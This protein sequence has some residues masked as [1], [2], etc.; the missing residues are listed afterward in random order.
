M[1]TSYYGL[2]STTIDFGNADDLTLTGGGSSSAYNAGSQ[3]FNF[4]GF[5]MRIIPHGGATSALGALAAGNG[6]GWLLDNTSLVGASIP[7]GVWTAILNLKSSDSSATGDLYVRFSYVDVSGPTFTT[8]GDAVLTAQTITTAGAQYTLTSGSITGFTFPAGTKLYMEIWFNQQSGGSATNLIS[9]KQATTSS[10][11]PGA[12][13]GFEITLPAAGPTNLNLAATGAIVFGGSASLGVNLAATGALVLGGSAG[14]TLTYQAPTIPPAP[15]P[16]ISV[17]VPSYTSDGTYPASRSNN[18]TYGDAWNSARPPSV[19]SPCWLAYDLSGVAVGSR[20][21]CVMALINEQGNLYYNTDTSQ[22]ANLFA[23]YTIEANAAA[24]GGAAPGSGWVQL[25]SV[26]GNLYPTR[27]HIVDLTGYNWVRFVCTKSNGTNPNNNLAL[28]VDIHDAHLGVMDRWLFIGD[29][30][31]LE[32]QLHADLGG[33][34]WGYGGSLPQLVNG[35]TVGTFYPQATD[36][37]NGGETMAWA[38]TNKAGL[39]NGFSGGFVSIAMGTNDANQNFLYAPGGTECTTYY[40]HLLAVIDAALALNNVVVVPYIPYGSNNGGDLGA[41]AKVFND[42]VDAHLPTDRPSVKR[43]P[44][45]WTFF[46]AN[47]GLIRDGIHPTYTEVSGARSGYE[48]QHRLW[49]TW[50][51][52]NIYDYAI[53]PFQMVFART[54]SAARLA[55]IF[56]RETTVAQPLSTMDSTVTVTRA[57]DGTFPAMS[58]ISTVVTFPDGTTTTYTLAGGA[59]SALGS[60]KYRL[61]YTTKGAGVHRERWTFTAADGSVGVYDNLVGVTY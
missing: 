21:L 12:S 36:A 46:N 40:T 14:L 55:A 6:H 18:S 48:E 60:G 7:T 30:I 42:Y 4:N 20:K 49:Q 8:I 45:F 22:A 44:D 41:N 29:S 13:G 23:D 25:V 38:D 37:G 54:P 10:G 58:T 53:P 5:F 57:I 27:H 33:G 15:M 34:E 52:A 2:S 51:L 17:G 56:S 31:T 59:I 16:L 28:Q 47:P 35:G 11:V 32:G 3:T 1:S 61:T 39:L 24:G 9:V 26:T 43:G 19:G 50:L